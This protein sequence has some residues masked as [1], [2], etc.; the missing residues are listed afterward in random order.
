M[1]TKADFSE[2][3]K[4]V[5][6]EVEAEVGSFRD[7]LQADIKLVRMELSLRIGKIED[8]LKNIEIRSNSIEKTLQQIGKDVK[9]LKRDVSVSIK[10]FDEQGVSLRKR[11]EKLE[12]RIQVVQ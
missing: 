11:V 5:R 1:L 4:I 2:I 8:R 9:K 7:E 10:M 6:E 3:R 12:E